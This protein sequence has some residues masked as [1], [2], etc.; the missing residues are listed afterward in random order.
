MVFPTMKLINYRGG[1][2][3]FS[4]PIG[5]V[6][7]YEP[8]GGGT[9]Y[10]D[11]PDSG[12]LRLNVLEFESPDKSAEDMAQQALQ[13]FETT[14]LPSGFQMRKRVAPAI[15]NNEALNIHRWE[16]AVPV[17]PHCL[18]M[19][20]FAHTVVAGQENDPRIASELAMIDN[21]VRDAVY[22]Q[23]LGIRGEYAT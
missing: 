22:S 9:F 6:E 11:R 3:R 16:V 17:P 1:V 21:C 2:V 10:E 18:R 15:E 5:W 20:V 12:T 7:E 4:L 8:L 23:E 14:L 19:C 13:A